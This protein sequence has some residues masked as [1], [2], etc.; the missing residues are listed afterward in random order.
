[1][2]AFGDHESASDTWPPL[3]TVRLPNQQM[4]REALRM[5]I[6]AA[7]GLSVSDAMIEDPVELIERES[8]SPPPRTERS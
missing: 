8:T 2:V 3:T 4:G 7:D 5:T 1:V 6:R